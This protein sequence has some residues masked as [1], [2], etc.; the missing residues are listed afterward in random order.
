M[1]IIASSD[2]FDAA[3][4][5]LEALEFFTPHWKVCLKLFIDGKPLFDVTFNGTR[6]SKKKLMLDVVCMRDGFEKNE[7]TDIGF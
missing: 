2:L 7:I 3:F 1:Q 4:T 5:L 6:T